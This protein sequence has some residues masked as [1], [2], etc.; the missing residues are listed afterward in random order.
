M[1]Y[2]QGD[3][4]GIGTESSFAIISLMTVALY[5]PSV[6]RA[7]L[8]GSIPINTIVGSPCICKWTTCC[9]HKGHLKSQTNA[10]LAVPHLQ[11]CA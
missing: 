9:Q 8:L 5:I 4:E 7:G 10:F 2:N 1:S 11:L 3:A 6:R